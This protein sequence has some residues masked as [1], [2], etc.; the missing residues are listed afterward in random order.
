MNALGRW[1]FVEA[2]AKR[3]AIVRILV[4]A[5]GIQLLTKAYDAYAQIARQA[6]EQWWPLGPMKILDAPLDPAVFDVWQAVHY[7]LAWCFVLGFGW[8]VLAPICAVSLICF[9]SYRTSWGSTLHSDNLFVLHTLC[10]ALGPAASAWSLDAEI[11][12]RWPNRLRWLRSEPLPDIDWRYGWTL[13][14]MGAVAVITY[15]LAGVAKVV[16]NAQGWLTGTN[17]VAQV[18]KDALYKEF[19]SPPS[20]PNE[21]VP[22]LYDHPELMLVPSILTLVIE[23]GAPLALL[24]RRLSWLWSFGAWSMHKGIDRIMGI[25]FD[26]PLSG[27]AFACFFPLDVWV[28]RAYELGRRVSSTLLSKRIE[29]S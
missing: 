22:W 8:R 5:Y 24:D 26:Y 13:R 4:G 17:L 29:S 12:R 1:W 25:P 14:L 18:G 23:V 21:I 10:L 15:L 16:T 11:A 19:V 20:Q 3:V 6:P 28:E 9:L 7:A 27:V 2:P